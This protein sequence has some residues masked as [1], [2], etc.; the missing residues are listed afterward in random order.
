MTKLELNEYLEKFKESGQIFVHATGLVGARL[1][2]E[3]YFNEGI[4]KN[5]NNSILSTIMLLDDRKNVLNEILSYYFKNYNIKFIV[6]IP[7]QIDNIYLGKVDKNYASKSAGNQ[8]ESVSI[9]DEMDL[10]C[11]PKELILGAVVQN[12]IG[13][14][15][16]ENPNHYSKTNEAKNNLINYL[17]KDNL[18]EMY[19]GLKEYNEDDI[20]FA[21][22]YFNIPQ[23]MLDR[24][25]ELKEKQAHK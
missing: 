21:E 7:E 13:Y 6:T 9:F 19:S 22:L 11:V 14:E 23:F 1:G 2:L 16:F 24:F 12:G 20:K 25:E 3:K 17:H 18:T 10:T 15:F 4:L 5:K 8:W